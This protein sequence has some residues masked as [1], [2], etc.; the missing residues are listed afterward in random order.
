MHGHTWSLEDSKLSKRDIP[1]RRVKSV[2]LRNVFTKLGT[3][4]LLKCLWAILFFCSSIYLWSFKTWF[5]ILAVFSDFESSYLNPHQK[6]KIWSVSQMRRKLPEAGISNRS[7]KFFSN[8]CKKKE[9]WWWS[10]TRE[11]ERGGIWVRARK[12]TGRTLSVVCHSSTATCTKT[13]SLFLWYLW[14]L[15]W[16]QMFCFSQILFACHNAVVVVVIVFTG[17][18]LKRFFAAVVLGD[19]SSKN[20]WF[21]DYEAPAFLPG[22]W[23]L[24]LHSQLPQKRSKLKFRNSPEVIGG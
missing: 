15:I 6:K 23:H 20:Q 12:R 10:W 9:W 16:L 13:A 8:S 5:K 22:E 19:S 21:I 7:F 18:V 24:E 1:H 3:C 11:K 17:F 4:Q 2:T 14:V